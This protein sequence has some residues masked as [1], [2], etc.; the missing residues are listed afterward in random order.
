MGGGQ[1]RELTS[2]FKRLYCRCPAVGCSNRRKT[3]WIHAD[4]EGD[5]YL[6]NKAYTLCAKCKRYSKLVHSTWACEKHAGDYRPSDP[7]TLKHALYIGFQM[8]GDDEDDDWG[9]TLLENL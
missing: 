4:C 5:L 8:G 3:H 9:K 2:D 6:D 1:T 7:K